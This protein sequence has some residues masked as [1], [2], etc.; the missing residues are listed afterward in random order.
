M[1][2]I[3]FGMVTVSECHRVG[4]VSSSVLVWWASCEASCGDWFSRRRGYWRSLSS[5]Q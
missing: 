3:V 1:D 2:R 4:S 5:C